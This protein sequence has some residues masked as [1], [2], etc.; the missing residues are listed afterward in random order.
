MTS[1]LSAMSAAHSL[2]A[3]W[4]RAVI[5]AT[6]AWSKKAQRCVIGISARYRL[7]SILRFYWKDLL[8]P[9]RCALSTIERQSRRTIMY[10]FEPPPTQLDLNFTLFGIH[11]RVHPMF[12]VVTAI[13][14]SNQ[15]DAK[16]VLLWIAVV[17][18]S[19]LIHEMGH[20]LLGRSFGSDGHI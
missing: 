12:W 5:G 7:Q 4:A 11:V 16:Y 9:I 1:P 18:V 6:A 19:V 17:F 3:F 2:M 8:L 15:R 10:L 13:L 20:V 14:G